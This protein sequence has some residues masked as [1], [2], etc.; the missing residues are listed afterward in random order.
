MRSRARCSIGIPGNFRASKTP[1]ESDHKTRTKLVK[2]LGGLV[3]CIAD[4]VVEWG[5]EMQPRLALSAP[6]K[7]QYAD[8]KDGTMEAECVCIVVV[9]DAETLSRTKVDR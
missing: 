1:V 4:P 9:N 6:D 5:V 8:F 7:F 2:K 3:G